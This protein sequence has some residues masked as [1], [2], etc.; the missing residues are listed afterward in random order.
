MLHFKI[1]IKILPFSKTNFSE[2]P[3]HLKPRY[4]IIL[5]GMVK[6]NVCLFVPLLILFAEKF[7]FC[8]KATYS[9]LW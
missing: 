2:C 1:T 4:G 5:K 8:K 3:H 6:L 9:C 7:S